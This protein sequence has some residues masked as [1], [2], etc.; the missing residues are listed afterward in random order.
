MPTSESSNEFYDQVFERYIRIRPTGY[1][2]YRKT[3]KSLLYFVQ[4][5]PITEGVLRGYDVTSVATR[6]DVEN[7]EDTTEAAQE[8]ELGH[9]CA[10]GAYNACLQCLQKFGEKVCTI[11]C[12]CLK[13]K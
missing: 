2:P 6:S 7:T 13:T 10:T 12:A 3:G 8:A 4:S 11:A 5:N 1:L 9:Y